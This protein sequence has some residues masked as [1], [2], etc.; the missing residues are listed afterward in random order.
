MGAPYAIRVGPTVIEAWSVVRLPFE[1]K[2][3]ARDFRD[4]LRAAL[5]GSSA[6]TGHLHAVYGAAESGRPVDA[7][8]ILLYNVGTA[9]LRHLMTAGVSFERSFQHPLPPVNSGLP[10]AGLHH[11]RYEFGGSPALQYWSRGEQLASF[12][13]VP[14]SSLAKPGPV[15]AAL[16][17]HAEPPPRESG[18]VGPFIVDVSIGDAHRERRP[19]AA[20][21]VKPVLD[22]VISAY[23]S[24]EGDCALVAERL[25]NLGLGDPSRLQREL[26]DPVWNVLGS[27]VLVWPFGPAG[28]QW[29]PADDLCV[30]AH[31]RP[32]SVPL[33]RSG[34]RWRLAGAIHA[35]L[36]SG[37]VPPSELEPD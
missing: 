7:E 34:P 35:A 19:S 18:Y 21:Q 15:W 30:A 11:H 13:D 31:V 4:A 36:P 20:D 17:A 9:C 26:G 12:V 6:G 27:R 24:H 5:R 33:D 23:H 37:A 14:V 28:V 8:N 16:R 3:T 10:S 29:N 1:P 2:G 22:G 32:V 25:A